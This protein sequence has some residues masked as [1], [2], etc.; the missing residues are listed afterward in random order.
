MLDIAALAYSK[1]G[2]AQIDATII[3]FTNKYNFNLLRPVTYI[4]QTIDP[5]W[6][7]LIPTPNHPEFPSAHSTIGS[8]VTSM[9][10]DVFGNNFQITL[11]TYDYIPLPSRSYNS[12]E[13]LNTEMANSRVF[14]GIHYQL[15]CDKSSVQGKKVAQNILSTVHFLKE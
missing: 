13:E 6:A 3:C 14:G 1:V 8:A 12:F 4:K 7:T 2:I 10:T 15:T 9:L 5:G 11:H